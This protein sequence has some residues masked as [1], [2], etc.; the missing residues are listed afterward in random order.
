MPSWKLTKKEEF[1]RVFSLGKKLSQSGIAAWVMPSLQARL[2]FA[3]SRK[4]GSAVR[5]NQF[6]RR[7]RA[8]FQKCYGQLLPA[9]IVITAVSTKGWIEYSQIE[10]FVAN[11]LVQHENRREKSID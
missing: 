1:D 11:N 2:G 4:Y 3:I 6:K 5:R 10:Q 8:V 9:D 7:V